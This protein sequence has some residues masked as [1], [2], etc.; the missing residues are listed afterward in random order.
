[1]LPLLFSCTEKIEVNAPYEDI[2]VVYGVLDS[3]KERQDIRVSKA[4]QAEENAFNYAARTDLSVRSLDVRL[5]GNGKIWF[6]TEKDSVL[7][8][9]TEGDFFPYTSVYQFETR[10]EDRLIPGETYQLEIR[11]PLDSA[12]FLNAFTQIPPAPTIIFPAIT[13]NQG[14]FCLQTLSI[15]DSVRVIFRKQEDETLVPASQF[16]IRVVLNYET[17]G[18]AQKITFGPTRLFDE[19]ISCSNTG[20]NTLCYLFKDRTILRSL[21]SQLGN[22]INNAKFLP[23]PACSDAPI[24]LSHAMEVQVTA[25][26]SFLAKY[27]QANDPRYLNLNTIRREY[28]NISGTAKAVGIFGSI[29]WD[30]QPVRLT[31]CGEYL[32]GFKPDFVSTNCE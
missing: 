4:F 31:P 8:D 12:F 1:M 30:N 29:A 16:E 6:A 3:Q 2:W 26:D 13:R 20:R 19:S 11:D 9:A 22:S 7:K 25:V 10:E 18:I 15:E 21:Q 14:K 5:K 24:D 28:S 17:N 32:L 23:L 27:I